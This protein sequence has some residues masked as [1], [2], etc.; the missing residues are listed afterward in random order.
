MSSPVSRGVVF[1]GVDGS[2]GDESRADLGAGGRRGFRP[3]EVLFT[4]NDAKARRYRQGRGLGEPP[5]ADEP[6]Q[7]P[8]GLA[9]GRSPPGGR[10]MRGGHGRGGGIR[11]EAAPQ[12]PEALAGGWVGPAFL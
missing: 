4:P 11:A 12:V 1:S 9:G 3:P 6:R 5:D 8:G 7:V 2:G 10:A